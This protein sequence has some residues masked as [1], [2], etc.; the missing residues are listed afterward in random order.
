MEAGIDM[1]LLRGIATV[2]A[3]LAFVAVVAWAYGKQ[4]RDAFKSAARL[5]LEEDDGSE[6]RS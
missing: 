6:I 1:G 5:P 4:P 2:F 3:L